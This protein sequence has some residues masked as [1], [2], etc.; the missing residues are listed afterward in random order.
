MSATIWTSGTWNVICSKCGIEKPT[1]EFYTHSNGKPRKQCKTCR[2]TDN[3]NWCVKSPRSRQ[4]HFE[5]YRINNKEKILQ[6]TRTWRKNNLEYDAQR[7][8]E[9]TI[10]KTQRIPL[11]ADKIKI[12]EIYLNCPDGFHV[13]HI[14]P[15]RGKY[16]SGLHVET[17]LQYLPAIENIRKR[18]N[19]AV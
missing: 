11:W 16:V 1:T 10:C 3:M 18:N 6:A 13:D 14:I 19:Y 9:R 7:Q 17:N 15:L 2:N 12:R 8:R 4:K 5:K